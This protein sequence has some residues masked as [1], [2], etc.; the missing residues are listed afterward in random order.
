MM[1][2]EVNVC[3]DMVVTVTKND[4]DLG[5]HVRKHPPLCDKSKEEF[6][7]RFTKQLLACYELCVKQKNCELR[8]D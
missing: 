6:K 7:K 4:I 2:R 3:A 8:L 1:R 5:E